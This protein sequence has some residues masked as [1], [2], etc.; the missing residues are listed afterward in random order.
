M[1]PLR[2]ILFIITAVLLIAILIAGLVTVATQNASGRYSSVCTVDDESRE[3]IIEKF[4]KYESPEQLIIGVTNYICLNYRYEKKFYI[5]HFDFA[6]MLR[7]DTGLCFDFA[8][9]SKCIITV[10]A[11]YK[12]WDDVKVYVVDIDVYTKNAHSYNYLCA[13]DKQYYFDTT[14][15]LARFTKGKMPRYYNDI[16]DMTIREYAESYGE[17]VYCLR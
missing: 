5:Q 4:G 17:K 1:S 3:W 2:K 9:F 10:I 11:D 13:G 12:G 14:A 7:S 6:E 8:S 16:G 15:D